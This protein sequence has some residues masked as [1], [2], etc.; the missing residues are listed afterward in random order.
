MESR[1]IDC[2]TTTTDAAEAFSDR[3][4]LSAMLDFEVA[5]A[6]AEAECGVIPAAAAS[7]IRRAAVA[8]AF[9]VEAMATSARRSATPTIPFVQAL[10]ALVREHDPLAARFVHWGATSQD[11]F[12]T[13]LVLCIA[14]ATMSMDDVHQ[15]LLH[16]LITLSDAH[17]GAVMV[18]RTLLQPATP[19]TFGLKAAGWAGAIARAWR[20]VSDGLDHALVLQLGGAAGTLA[21]LG[22]QGRVV[23][24]GVADRLGL[25]CPSAPWHAHRERLAS[26][27]GALA[28][29]VGT[30]G[31]MAGDIALLMQAEVGEV[32]ERGGGSSTMPQKR[33]PSGAALVV[34]ASHRLSGLTASMIGAMGQ[35][36]ERAVGGWHAE[37]PVIRD[38]VVVALSAL[39]TAVDLIDGLTVSPAR[40]RANLDATRGVIYAERL[41][42][43]LAAAIGRDEAVRLATEAV[44][45]CS[46]SGRTFAE[47]VRM[48]PV[49]S[50]MLPA[51]VLATLDDPAQYLGAAEV[52]RQQT[53]ADVR[54]TIS[55]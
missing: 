21:S 11:V 46:A 18:G 35:E 43:L 9:D 16:R 32:S 15:G 37:A 40:M 50:A 19:T 22:E 6:G 26:L 51:E 4:V 30:L 45:S 12:D 2:L 25:A 8:D 3:A 44:D 13:A 5:L 39:T 27:V 31:K 47:E 48:S 38:A 28:V 7:A 41:T 10:T 29:Y 54:A 34:A 23:Q 52:F 49:L 14:R 17:A 42:F 24:E 55:H 20:P 36:H 33:N 53:L 1:L